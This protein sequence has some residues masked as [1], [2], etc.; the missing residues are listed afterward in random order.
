M[1]VYFLMGYSPDSAASG[2]T[3]KIISLF[4]SLIFPTSPLV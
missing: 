2:A 1:L 3:E 4:L